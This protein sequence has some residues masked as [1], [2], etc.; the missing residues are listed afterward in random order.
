MRLGVL[1]IIIIIVVVIAILVVTRV[2][3]MGRSTPDKGDTSAEAPVAGPPARK[4]AY[5]KRLGGAFVITGI[6]ILIAGISL[7]KW[8]LQ[9]YAWS[10]IIVF[11]GL[12]MLFM[13]RKR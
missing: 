9:S 3:R 1:E 8:A 2:V 5:L 6:V 10:F 11:I 4:G 12:A 13:A 7:F